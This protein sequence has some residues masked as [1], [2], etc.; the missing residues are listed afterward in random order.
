LWEAGNGLVARYFGRV[1][2]VAAAVADWAPVE[3]LESPLYQA[4][5]SLSVFAQ[6]AGATQLASSGPVV[7]A[8][9]LR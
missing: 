2:S 1:E 7:A 5:S 8:V 6:R 9:S 3:S 4:D